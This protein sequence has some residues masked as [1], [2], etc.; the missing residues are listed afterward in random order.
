MVH[1]YLHEGS[2]LKIQSVILLKLTLRILILTKAIDMQVDSKSESITTSQH[3]SL[4]RRCLAPAHNP[5]WKKA[6]F[7]DEAE[8]KYLMKVAGAADAG[9]HYLA[10]FIWLH[11]LVDFGGADSGLMLHVDA[12]VCT[13]IC[14]RLHAH[15]RTCLRAS[16]RRCR[17]ACMHMHRCAWCGSFCRAVCGGGCPPRCACEP[18]RSSTR[19]SVRTIPTARANAMGYGQWPM[20]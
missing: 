8:W 18:R 19:R 3:V 14:T 4:R 5:E 20:G 16:A 1:Y 9:K 11:T 10:P 12:H 17:S 13:Q 2:F 7:A 15:L 6:R